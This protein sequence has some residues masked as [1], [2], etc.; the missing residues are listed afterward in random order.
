[1]AD[2]IL[3]ELKLRDN[4][5]DPDWA[6]E[7]FGFRVQS[8]KFENISSLEG[9]ASSKWMR[10]LHLES[11]FGIKTYVVKVAP[12]P[13]IE[14]RFEL[15]R[16]ALFYK[17]LGPELV[18]IIP[19]CIYTKGNMETGSKL[20]IMED[21]NGILSGKLI[22][23]DHPHTWAYKAEVEKLTSEGPGVE[24]IIEGTFCHTAMLH[25]KYWMS[26]SLQ[27]YEWLALRQ[28]DNKEN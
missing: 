26:E 7:E 5:I 27:N 18:G 4:E 24:K 13:I 21:L 3:N 9:G 22:G 12:K 8:G 15:A 10:K 1:M 25:A 11:E 16:E 2:I 6:S 19:S 17:E 23:P 14:E 20:I 28:K